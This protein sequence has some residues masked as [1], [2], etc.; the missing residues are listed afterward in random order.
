MAADALRTYR[1]LVAVFSV[2]T[3]N[4]AENQ[5]GELDVDVRT[6]GIR[7]LNSVWALLPPDNLNTDFRTFPALSLRGGS[8]DVL[9]LINTT[10]FAT[11]P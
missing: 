6:L 1:R 11:L 5:A 4:E 8:R 7:L 3:V 9:P 2:E 10:R